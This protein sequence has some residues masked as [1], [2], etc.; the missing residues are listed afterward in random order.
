MTA[1]FPMVQPVAAMTV[2][3]LGDRLGPGA[4]EYLDM[5]H[6]DA[7]FEFPFGPGGAVRIEGKPAMADGVG[8]EPTVRSHAR[9]F[10]RP[11]PSTARPPIPFK[12]KLRNRPPHLKC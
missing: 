9:R 2:T 4:Y 8:F 6:E 5:F 12:P 3:A 10:S 1:R 7:V 11:L